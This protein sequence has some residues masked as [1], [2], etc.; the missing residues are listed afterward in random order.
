MRHV[1]PRPALDPNPLNKQGADSA[2]SI[3]SDALARALIEAGLDPS[4]VSQ[5]TQDYRQDIADIIENELVMDVL[6]DDLSNREALTFAGAFWTGHYSRFV[7]RARS[8]WRVATFLVKYPTLGTSDF[9]LSLLTDTFFADYPRPR[10]SISSLI[11]AWA[12]VGAFAAAQ[13]RLNAYPLSR[14][15]QHRRNQMDVLVEWERQICAR[16]EARRKARLVKAIKP[17]GKVR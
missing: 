4:T 16:A 11:N 12:K 14:W 13:R 9:P 8:V 7:E 10:T 17:K 6:A 1:I 2:A 5:K 15:S 3:D